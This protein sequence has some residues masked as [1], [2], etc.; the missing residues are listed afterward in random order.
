[1]QNRIARPGARLLAALAL[2]AVALLATGCGKQ[3]ED[4]ASQEAAITEAINA[5]LRDGRGLR[6]DAMK[7]ELRD[8]RL[9]G[10]EANVHVRF[11]SAGAPGGMEREYHLHREAGAW[12]VVESKGETHG[13]PQTRP[14]PPD[15]PPIPPEGT[16]GS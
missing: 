9:D 8:L 11:S 10:D 13:E 7:M 2:A 5:Y 1:M 3:A 16:Q 12:K 6:P 15:H 14:M 4:V